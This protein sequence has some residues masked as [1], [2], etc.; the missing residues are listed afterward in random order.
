M[1]IEKIITDVWD[2]SAK[3]RMWYDHDFYRGMMH[4]Y[5]NRKNTPKLNA[6]EFTRPPK[7]KMDMGELKKYYPAYYQELRGYLLQSMQKDEEG[8]YYSAIQEEAA[9]SRSKYLHMFEMDHIIPISK[10]GLTVK[11]NLQMILR[12]QNIRKGNNH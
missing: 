1:D 10:G 4:V 5:F 8:Y 7:E 12:S 2:N 3:V 9:P 6:P 11:E